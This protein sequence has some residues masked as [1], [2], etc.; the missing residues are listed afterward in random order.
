VSA[1]A[2][3]PTLLAATGLLACTDGP[4]TGDTGD[5]PDLAT[6]LAALTAPGPHNIGWREQ[7]IVYGDPAAFAD[8]KGGGSRELRG[9]FWYPTPDSSGT[10]ARY[11]G[12]V[13]AEGV[14]ADAT[15][16]GGPFP[17][18]VFS[19][20]S[21]GYAEN[22]SF[23]MEHFAS[24]GW[25]VA[26]FDHTGNTTGSGAVQDAAIYLQRPH[27]VSAMLDHIEADPE[28][29]PALSG[30]VVGSGHSFG[31]YTL[32]ALAGAPHDVVAI[33]A[34][35][36]DGSLTH[37]I[38]EGLN[39]DMLEAL[40]ADLSDPRIQTFMP[41]ASG[42]FSLFGN[43][44]IA[45]IDR[46]VLQITGSEDG[47]A[48]D[49]YWPA[50]QAQPGVGHLGMVLEGAGHQAFTDLAIALAGSIDGQVAMDHLRGVSLAWATHQLGD[51]DLADAFD[52]GANFGP[53]VS[54]QR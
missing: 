27:D 5:A 24:H 43:A 28:L 22:S 29:G 30:E 18:L 36:A 23:L 51:A 34:G 35:C 20:G 37:G 4:S 6:R 47:A 8:P 41:M 53:E 19:H 42:D 14:W 25:V 33:E 50:L 46:P 45:Q 26:A 16:A 32:Y 10:E 2:L 3:A 9:T 39:A 44:G 7:A 49:L 38:C 12:T 54:F 48:T 17:L 1:L 40:S 31:G 52:D 11:L 13:S 15:V 21:Q